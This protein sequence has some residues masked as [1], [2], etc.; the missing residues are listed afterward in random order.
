MTI[1]LNGTTGI[2]S[3]AETVGSTITYADTGILATYASSST[4]YNQVILQNSNSGTASSTDLI[5]SND[6]GTAST[7]YGDFGMNSSGWTGSLPFSAAN[8]VYLT[9]TSGPLSLGSVTS[10][11]VYIATNSTTAVTIDTSQNVGIGTSSP[12]YK[13]DV[14]GTIR[15]RGDYY[16]GFVSGSQA[17]VWWSQSNY[18]APAFQGL[19]SAGNVGDI[20]MQPGGGN[21]LVNTT[22]RTGGEKMA[23]WYSSNSGPAFN[24][25]DTTAQNGNT[26]IQFNNGATT[27]GAI[28]SNGTT[29]MTYGSGSD[30]RLK[31]NLSPLTGALAKVAQLQPKV[32]LWKT[33][34]SEFVGFIAHELQTVFPDAVVGEKDAVDANGNPKYQMVDAGSAS[35]I[36]TL[37][38]AIQELN[39]T[40]TDLQAKLKSAGVAGF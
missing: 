30:Y 13:L 20:V 32:G 28:T 17:G 33:D 36:A 3:P 4:S 31:E 26:F 16:F 34:S 19:T 5:V 25:R 18:A 38:A 15:G 22:T 11:P 9:S 37:T 40:I 8:V 35:I 1:V 27:A 24:I 23:L 7:Y 2:T 10:N 6:Q 39:A 21:L 14:N 12:S 29:T